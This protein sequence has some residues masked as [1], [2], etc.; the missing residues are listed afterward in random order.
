MKKELLPQ[1]QFVP[2]TDLAG[3]FG[4][5]HVL[6]GDY[7]RDME[8][9]INAFR[10]GSPDL[11]AIMGNRRMCLYDAPFAYQSGAELHQRLLTSDY[12][13][14]CAFLFHTKRQENG[15]PFGSVLRLDLETLR[16]DVEKHT[17]FPTG[18]E[19]EYP[20]GRTETVILRDWAAMEL[21]EKDALKSWRE[22]YSQ[23]DCE[24]AAQHYAQFSKELRQIAFSITDEGLLDL[25]N[26]NYMEQAQHSQEG[27]YRI[28]MGAAKELLLS[29]E[30]PVYRLLPSGPEKIAP[31]TAVTTGL[32]YEHY[33]EFAIAPEDRG[34]LDKRIRR[35]TDRLMGNRPPLH[36][37]T[38]RR[39]SPER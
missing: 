16:E 5:L 29:G 6:A 26:V 39:P 33:R 32:W 34:A 9:N 28:P 13:S 25:L 4:A 11:I 15:R 19:V 22:V 37:N 12:L 36:K 23:P 24:A 18:K 14:G 7:L 21:Y 27:F 2:E 17:I 3:F 20:D 31:I 35:E 30:A 8:H 38:E 1:V 10:H